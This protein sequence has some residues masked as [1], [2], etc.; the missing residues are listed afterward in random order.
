MGGMG[1]GQRT[2]VFTDIEGSTKLQQRLGPDYLE[3]PKVHDELVSRMVIEHGGSIENSMGDGVVAAFPT[4][5]RALAA[6][7][8]TRSGV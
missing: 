4:A 1:R 8:N 7:T 2:F 3:L 5:A 6:A